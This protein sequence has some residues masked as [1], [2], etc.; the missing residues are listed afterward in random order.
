MKLSTHFRQLLQ[1]T[2]ARAQVKANSNI[3]LTIPMCTKYAKGL[4]L[5]NF[6]QL[7]VIVNYLQLI[8]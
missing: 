5:S 7:C 6:K 1:N 8:K 3:K 4:F 2:T